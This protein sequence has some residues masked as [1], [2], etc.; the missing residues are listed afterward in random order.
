MKNV[1]RQ[2]VCSHR[3]PSFS[4]VLVFESLVYVHIV[5]KEISKV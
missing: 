5:N 2:E 3:K 1:I 4:H